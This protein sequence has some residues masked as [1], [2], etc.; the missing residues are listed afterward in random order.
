MNA[1]IA[2]EA[3]NM[4]NTPLPTSR[5]R[6]RTVSRK[7][8]SVP[9]SVGAVRNVTTSHETVVKPITT[10]SCTQSASGAPP[11]AGHTKRRNAA[12]R[13]EDTIPA[14]SLHALTRIQSP[15]APTA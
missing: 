15:R 7:R 10:R 8:A 13:N 5:P 6:A 9:A 2:T 4:H 1:K 14:T 12:A 11:Q 3:R